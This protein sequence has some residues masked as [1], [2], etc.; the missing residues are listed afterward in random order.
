MGE[1]FGASLTV[2][3]INGDF[4]DDLIVGAPH[5]SVKRDEGRVYVFLGREGHT[6]MKM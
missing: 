2:G 6:V 4:L 1:Y 3:D 5:F